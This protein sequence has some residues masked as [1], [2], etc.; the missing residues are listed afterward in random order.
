MNNN[1]FLM[2]DFIQRPSKSRFIE[3][4]EDELEQFVLAHS[5][6]SEMMCKKLHLD[7][8][9]IPFKTGGSS[10]ELFAFSNDPNT[11]MK[12]T[13]YSLYKR[14]E[15]SRNKDRISKYLKNIK[16]ELEISI[17]LKQN[18]EI[19]ENVLVPID[20]GYCSDDIK[21]FYILF[22]KLENS[23][24]DVLDNNFHLLNNTKFIKRILIDV[25]IGLK[26]LQSLNIIHKDL[27]C[28][29]ILLTSNDYEKCR[30][31]ISDFGISKVE[32][33]LEP[34]KVFT[35]I[36]KLISNL[37]NKY[38]DTKNIL[39]ELDV[40]LDSYYSDLAK[41]MSRKYRNLEG[42]IDILVIDT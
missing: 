38:P 31:V 1:S 28:R 12:K 36:A 7:S 37:A 14:S 42:L 26:S 24:E 6:S 33:E 16:G 10:W 3:D 8:F 17:I 25:L 27:E 18:K 21:T 22:D 5:K 35:D 30:F 39:K 13:N 9:L 29:N 23:L 41:E 32:D 11:L 15:P 4:D 34:K 40:N 19:L 2:D 20:I